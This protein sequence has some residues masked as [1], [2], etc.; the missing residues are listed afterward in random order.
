MSSLNSIIKFCIIVAV[1]A[2]VGAV[3][4]IRAASLDRK[5]VESAVSE[6][7]KLADAKN[8]T[9][10]DKLLVERAVM[11]SPGS[12]GRNCRPLLNYTRAY[13]LTQQAAAGAAAE[14]RRLLGAAVDVYQQVL[15]DVP[16]HGPTLDNLVDIGRQLNDVDLVESLLERAIASNLQQRLSYAITL[17]DLLRDN[18]RLE[19]ALSLYKQAAIWGPTSPQPR[20]RIVDIHAQLPSNRLSELAQRLDQWVADFPTVAERGYRLLIERS[21]SDGNSGEAENYLLAWVGAMASGGSLSSKRVD[22]LYRI[23]PFEPLEQLR[24]FL[25][26]FDYP[27][28]W[29]QD[30]NKPRQRQA[31]TQAAIAIGYQELERSGPMMAKRRWNRTLGDFAPKSYQY[32][33][34]LIDFPNARLGLQTALALLYYQY[35]KVAT[36]DEFNRLIWGIF[37]SKGDAYKANDLRSI[38]QHHTILGTIFAR[39]PKLENKGHRAFNA[40]FQLHYAIRTANRRSEN[41]EPY[42]PLPWLKMMLANVCEEPSEVV[43]SSWND[44]FLEYCRDE[45]RNSAVGSL[46]LDAAQ[47]YLDTDELPKASAMLKKAERFD[48]NSSDQDAL[49]TTSDILLARQKLP[50]FA[51]ETES[52]NSS[53]DLLENPLYSWITDDGFELA[54]SSFIQRQQFKTLSDYTSSIMSASD[55]A[56]AAQKKLDRVKPLL[57]LSAKRLEIAGTNDELR[58]ASLAPLG[59]RYT[60]EKNCPGPEKEDL[61][62]VQAGLKLLIE[63]GLVVDGSTGPATKSALRSFQNAYGLEVDGKAGSLTKGKLRQIL[64]E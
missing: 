40:V 64:C 48:L 11:C 10:A 35:P 39:Q 30:Y 21:I 23:W 24:G 53:R 4:S 14:K 16:A 34:N 58:I 20:I 42:Q 7:E 15:V 9:E 13:L 51:L 43:R 29:W 52:I 25:D 12:A 18:E 63:P 62:W 54:Q 60:S 19:D 33:G 56:N 1:L 2:S 50:K 17:G 49:N 61:L 59:I 27:A 46:Y 31:I 28:S 3:Q 57:D 36:V 45:D 44:E 5:Q 22:D 32:F 8:W 38:Q 26:D 55:S 6:A 41:G 47:A 37:Q